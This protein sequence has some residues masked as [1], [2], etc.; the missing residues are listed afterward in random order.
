M[1]RRKIEYKRLILCL[2]GRPDNFD[3][4]PKFVFHDYIGQPLAS[5]DPTSIANCPSDC[6]FATADRR[7]AFHYR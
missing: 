6:F 7:C 1:M 4:S 2:S 5:L 3:R